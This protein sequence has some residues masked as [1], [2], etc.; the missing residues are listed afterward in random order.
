MSSGR[1]P[2]PSSSTSTV[3]S[4]R[5]PR[6]RTRTDPPRGVWRNGVVDEDHDQLAET[7]LVAADHRRLGIEP[8]GHAA[9]AGELHERPRALGRDVAQVDRQSVQ[10]DRPGVRAGEEEQVVDQRRH[11][12]DLDVDVVEGLG[13]LRLAAGPAEMLDGAADHGERGAQLVARVGREL[14]L[15]AQG[16]PLGIERVA[17]RHEGPAGVDGAEGHGDEDHDSA[18]HDQ[19]AQERVERLLLRRAVLDHLDVDRPD[20]RIDPLRSSPGSAGG[21]SW[22][23]G[24][25]CRRS[26]PPR[27]SS[28]RAGRPG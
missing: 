18:A 21:R 26:P 27:A 24:R 14:A 16:G 13:R 4:W 17:D 8:E 7:S 12:A 22:R 23:A 11:L 9:I 2:G 10:A 6:T 20:R 1:M 15:A 19:H 5:S 25:R 28:A 3:T